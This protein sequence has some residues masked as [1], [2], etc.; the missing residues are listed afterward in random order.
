MLLKRELLKDPG[1]FD[2]GPKHLG[3]YRPTRINIHYSKAAKLQVL[4]VTEKLQKTYEI[5]QALAF[6]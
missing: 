6:F 4:S 5:G 1:E 3:D 2:V